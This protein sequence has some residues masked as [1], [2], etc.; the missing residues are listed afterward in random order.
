MPKTTE[1]SAFFVERYMNLWIRKQLMLHHA[2]INLS[3]DLLDHE[4]QI[5]EYRSS[6]LIYAYQQELINQNFDTTILSK[7]VDDYYSQYHEKFKLSK[8][9]GLWRI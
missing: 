4:K 9:K 7:D 2:G 5:R 1:D 3:D 8:M 6:L